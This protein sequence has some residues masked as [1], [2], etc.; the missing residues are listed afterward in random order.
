MDKR[1]KHIAWCDAG[2]YSE[3]RAVA[4]EEHHTRTRSLETRREPEDKSS[5]YEG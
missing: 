5:S 1:R 3:E 2:S 4:S